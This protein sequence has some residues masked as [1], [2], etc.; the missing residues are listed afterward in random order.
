MVEQNP[1]LTPETQVLIEKAQ[2]GD[3]DAQCNLG[4]MYEKGKGVAQSD[5]KAVEYYRLAAEQGNARGQCYLG[6][7]YRQGKGVAQSD[8]KAVEYFQLAAEQGDA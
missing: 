2:S 7:M 5:E 6:V 8:E 3:A 1:K 4:V